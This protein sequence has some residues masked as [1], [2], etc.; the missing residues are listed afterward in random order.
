MVIKFEIG[1][2]IYGLDREDGDYEGRVFKGKA[3]EVNI[4][5][6]LPEDASVELKAADGEE[7]KFYLHE[8]YLTMD[9][10]LAAVK[11]YLDGDR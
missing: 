3:I 10:L 7:H 4:E 1:Q 6:K 5:G 9:E 11:E 2:I 8:V